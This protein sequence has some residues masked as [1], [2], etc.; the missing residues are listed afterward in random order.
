MST[1]KTPADGAAA[2]RQAIIRH[3]QRKLKY[4][5]FVEQMAWREEIEWLRGRAKRCQSRP[6]GLGRKPKT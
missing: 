5:P 2:E 6:G 4:L 1:L 3:M